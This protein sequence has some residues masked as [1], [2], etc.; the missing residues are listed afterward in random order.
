MCSRAEEGWGSHD[1]WRRLLRG[2]A[3]LL[4]QPWLWPL[5]LCSA[6]MLCRAG[7]CPCS[8]L[9]HHLQSACFL[10]ALLVSCGE[11]MLPSWW[12]LKTSIH[13][14]LWRVPPSRC[15]SS[16]LVWVERRA[17]PDSCL[18]YPWAGILPRW[19]KSRSFFLRGTCLVCLLG[20][21]IYSHLVASP[22]HHIAV[23]MCEH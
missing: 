22:L 19:N 20:P 12:H 23:T 10:S 17:W 6:C 7:R 1:R 8:Q 15:L 3:R 4:P 2:R 16:G 18:T 11:G 9:H 5:R 13:L 14:C 21:L